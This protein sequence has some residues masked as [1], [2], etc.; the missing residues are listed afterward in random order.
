MTQLEF[1]V[2]LRVTR[3]VLILLLLL[4]EKS[5]SLEEPSSLFGKAVLTVFKNNQASVSMIQRQLK[6]HYRSGDC[7]VR[8]RTLREY[9]S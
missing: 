2:T 7:A 1:Q 3:I 4:V 8:R 9:S 6:L 5:S